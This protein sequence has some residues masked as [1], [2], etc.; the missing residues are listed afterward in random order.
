MVLPTNV[1]SANKLFDG[2]GLLAAGMGR[3]GRATANWNMQTRAKLVDKQL[4][5]RN[6]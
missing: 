5:T 4:V 3:T 2:D 6:F 1:L